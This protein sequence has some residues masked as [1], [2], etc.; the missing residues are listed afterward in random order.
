MNIN[1]LLLTEI[2]DR[3]EYGYY[4]E[5]IEHFL[6]SPCDFRNRQSEAIQI[7]ENIMAAHGK[8]KLRSQIAELARVEY[9]IRELEP[10][11][12][13]HVVHALLS[14]IL[15]IYINEKFL[16]LSPGTKIDTFQWKLAGL[17]HDI[18]YPVQVA[19]KDLLRP[20]A[21]KVNEIKKTLDVKSS[22]VRFKVVPIGFERLTR[23]SDSFDLIQKRL[24]EWKLEIDA[25]KEYKQ[26]INTGKIC[27][28]MLSAL[29]VLYVVD[30]MYA[31]HNHG[32]K[33][34]YIDAEGSNWNQAYFEKDVISACSAIYIHNLPSRCFKSAKIDRAR[35]PVAFLL[36]LSDCLQEWERPSLRNPAGFSAEKFDIEVKDEQLILRAHVPKAKKKKMREEIAIALICSD[37]LI[38]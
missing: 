17:F 35:A 9:A 38:C 5:E 13:D 27:H 16:G 10:H 8:E 36:K 1:S 24:D 26:Q 20:Y 18:G 31:K 28:G 7:I 32:R 4:Q 6:T 29:T 12:R 11:L 22:D 15:G 19:A 30:L 25:R 23:G 33:H 21:D 37:V 14:F 3:C 2:K 34:S